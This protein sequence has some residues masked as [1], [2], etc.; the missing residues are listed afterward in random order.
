[1]RRSWKVT[2]V[3]VVGAVTLASAIIAGGSTVAPTGSAAARP[4]AR[5]LT[6]AHGVFL[7]YLRHELPTA[8]LARHSK[9]ATLTYYYNWSGYADSSTTTGK[10]TQ[11]SGSWT[12]PTLTCTPEDEIESSWVG[13]DGLTDPTVEQTGTSAQCFEGT[14][15]YYSWY[16]MYP[17]GTEVLGSTVKAGDAISASLVRTG[18]SYKISLTDST[19]SGNSGSE[20]ETCATTTCLDTSAEW[21]VERPE[22]SSTGIVPLADYGSTG[23]THAKVNS[24]KVISSSGFTAD[25]IEMVDSTDTYLLETTSS[26]GTGGNNFTSAWAN[27][28]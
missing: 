28:Y 8:L 3:A 11:V 19:T 26:L 23:F 27:S 5:L 18:K 24:T 16:E 25:Q 17:A 6:E 21:I 4:N 12:V 2:I 22:Y 9:N 15:V 13:L 20:T 10:F 1:M 14:P 7:Q